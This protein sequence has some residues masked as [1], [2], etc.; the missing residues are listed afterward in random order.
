MNKFEKLLKRVDREGMTAAYYEGE[1]YL[2]VSDRRI[3]IY[4]NIEKASAEG[5]RRAERDSIPLQNVKKV[6]N[7]FTIEYEVDGKTLVM[8]SKAVK[9]ATVDGQAVVGVI[10]GRF[11]LMDDMKGASEVVGTGEY[12][13]EVVPDVLLNAWYLQRFIPIGGVSLSVNESG[14]VAAEYKFKYK[15]EIHSA[16]LSTMS[17]DCVERIRKYMNSGEVLI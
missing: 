15:G 6:L 13:K 5:S 14:W 7:S 9:D 4:K 11:V 17:D 3:I 2:V 16:L 12:T 8:F 10:N 1:N